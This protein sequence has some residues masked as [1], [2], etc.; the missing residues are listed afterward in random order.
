LRTAKAKAEAMIEALISTFY[1]WASS[2][3]KTRRTT[4]LLVIELACLLEGYAR[5]CI[6]I[7]EDYNM[8]EPCPDHI[9]ENEYGRI[10]AIPNFPA[11]PE[12]GAYEFLNIEDYD[13]LI[14][15]KQR[16]EEA[17]HSPMSVWNITGDYAETEEAYATTLRDIHDEAVNLAHDIRHR[18]GLSVA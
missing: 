1:N 11:L 10:G 13:N 17:N 6:S 18:H 14:Q 16:V 8:R 12:S 2:K 9:S 3:F 4:N 5:E 15:F 7:V